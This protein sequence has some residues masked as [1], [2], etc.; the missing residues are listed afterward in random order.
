MERFCRENN[1]Q[2]KAMKEVH[3]LCLQLERL[4]ND[5]SNER[6]FQSVFSV[7]AITHPSEEQE[8]L[9]Q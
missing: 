9:L 7:E 1:L 8:K 3:Y 5:A 2:V 4:V 6:E